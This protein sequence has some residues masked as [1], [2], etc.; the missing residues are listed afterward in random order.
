MVCVCVF[1]GTIWDPEAP[2]LQRYLWFSAVG[3]QHCVWAGRNQ[4]VRRGSITYYLDG[5]HTPQS[6]EAS[7]EW[8][9]TETAPKD[10]VR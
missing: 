9:L 4:V 1:C 6:V 3:L 7:A 8:F 5:A 2:I 10:A